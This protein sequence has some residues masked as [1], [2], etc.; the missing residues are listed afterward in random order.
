[1]AQGQVQTGGQARATT[2]R[3]TAGVQRLVGQQTARLAERRALARSY[4][5]E[6]RELDRLKR[7]KA[8]W[9]RDRLVRSKKAELQATADKLSR[10]DAGL[11]TLAGQLKVQR[12]ALLA[13]IDRELALAPP[14]SRANLLRRTRSQTATALRPPVRKI[15][16]P[17]DSLDE[18]ADPVELAEQI[19]LIQQAERE[20]RREREVLR[21][22]EDRYGRM[23]RLREQRDRAGQLSELDRNDVRRSPGRVDGSGGRAGNEDSAGGDSDGASSG[24]PPAEDADPSEPAPDFG[25]GDL[26]DSAE[27]P[28]AVD[29]SFEQSS[30]AL[31]DVVDGPTLDS[32]R[33]A[34]RSPSPKRRAEVASR[35]RKQVESRMDRL[36]R[37]RQLIQQHL[38]K[39]RQR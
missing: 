20:L 36:Q 8:S 6:L 33:R 35:A 30:I 23:S 21:Q 28:A 31:A 22:R 11:R 13:A 34:G 1:V 25:S 9:R 10:V 32:L 17:D 24:E 37:S 2:D 7:S 15:I 14:Q 5:V 26:S 38:R 29:P 27:P 18:L 19:A 4:E 39:L 3:A 12:Q 16:L